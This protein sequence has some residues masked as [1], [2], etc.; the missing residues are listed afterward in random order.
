[1]ICNA[2]CGQCQRLM[3]QTLQF[4]NSQINAATD[5]SPGL[6]ICMNTRNRSDSV[7]LV[8]LRRKDVSLSALQAARI[9]FEATGTSQLEIW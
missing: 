2:A 8:V 3:K 4:G 7:V 6:S 1:M 9:S 5:F